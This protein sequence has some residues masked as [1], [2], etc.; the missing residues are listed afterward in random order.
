LSDNHRKT[1]TRS[2]TL[3]ENAGEKWRFLFGVL[4]GLPG[5]G[6]VKK[7]WLQRDS[8]LPTDGSQKESFEMPKKPIFV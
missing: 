7:Q 1:A 5:F 4:G 8:N 6:L 3:R 2:T